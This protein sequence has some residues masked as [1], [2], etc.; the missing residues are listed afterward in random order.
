MGVFVTNLGYSCNVPYFNSIPP[1]AILQSVLL[2]HGSPTNLQVVD[3]QWNKMHSGD[4]FGLDVAPP[5]K[6]NT[7]KFGGSRLAM[8]ALAASTL[9][10][11]EGNTGAKSLSEP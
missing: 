11:M 6:Q 8:R 7:S 10:P 4:V 2:R 5:P 1:F 3:W 9:L